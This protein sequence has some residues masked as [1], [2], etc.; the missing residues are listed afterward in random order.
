MIFSAVEF[1]VRLER[2]EQWLDRGPALVDTR[3]VTFVVP[4][5]E[6]SHMAE[7]VSALSD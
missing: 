2:A 6:S 3:I 5:A 7:F 1:K 4:V